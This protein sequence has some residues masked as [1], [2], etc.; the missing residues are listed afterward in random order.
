MKTISIDLYEFSE[1]STEAQD[2]ALSELQDINVNYDW[3]DGT[4]Q[5]AQNI[6]LVITGFDVYNYKISGELEV[7]NI[8]ACNKIVAEHGEECE[9]YKTAK[10]FI[11]AY[12]NC[13]PSQIEELEESNTRRLLNDYLK[14]LSDEYS[15]L[16]TAEAIKETIES[17]EYFFTKDG[18]RFFEK[19]L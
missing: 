16:Q 13:K 3:W 4:Y 15:Y 1:L 2:K 17:N 14:I 9:T 6:G 7:D 19:K 8:E 18:K 11:E 5:D 10:N 12:T